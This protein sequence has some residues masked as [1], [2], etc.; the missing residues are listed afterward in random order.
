[1]TAQREL[2]IARRRVRRSLIDAIWIPV[3]VGGILLLL[4]VLFSPS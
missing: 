4:T 2:A 1:L 3:V